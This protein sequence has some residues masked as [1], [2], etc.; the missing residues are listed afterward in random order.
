MK[1]QSKARTFMNHQV[2]MQ[3]KR[4]KDKIVIQVLQLP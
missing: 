2:L 4:L 1:L 3:T